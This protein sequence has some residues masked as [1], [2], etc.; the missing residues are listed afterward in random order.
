MCHCA[1][2]NAPDGA[3]C[4]LTRRGLHR[5]VGNLAGLNAPDGAGCSL[6][7]QWKQGEV[8]VDRL[9]APGGAG[10]SLTRHQRHFAHDGR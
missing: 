3:G 4:S 1:G 5:H 6:T 7:S 9:N 10:C 2:L 8:L